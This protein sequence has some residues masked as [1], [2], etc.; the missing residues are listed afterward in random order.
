MKLDM[1]TLMPFVVLFAV[2]AAAVYFSGALQLGGN[3]LYGQPTADQGRYIMTLV[4]KLGKKNP[5]FSKEQDQFLRR[6][7]KD[8]VSN[9][10]GKLF[11]RYSSDPVYAAN[12]DANLM[13]GTFLRSDTLTHLHRNIRHHK[14]RAH[15]G[16]SSKQRDMYLKSLK[17]Q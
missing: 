1:K 3:L 7:F 5:K 13:K 16:D 12:L 9:I 10:E 17:T 15:I 4:N 2:C 8:P 14:T 6:A 11:D